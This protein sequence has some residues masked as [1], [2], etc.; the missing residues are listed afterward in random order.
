MKKTPLTNLNNTSLDNSLDNQYNL[1]SHK[2]NDVLDDSLTK[3]L[4]KFLNSGL[5][6]D[7]ISQFFKSELF[8]NKKSNLND[9]EIKFSL[10][11]LR[12]K[13]VEDFGFVLLN[14]S[15]IN[16]IS[17]FLKDKNVCEIG[18]GTGWL[19]HNLKKNG[20]DITP[21]DY[22]P[23]IN[24]EFGFKTLHTQ[25]LNIEGV[26]YLK[27]NNPEVII[28]SWPDYDTNFASNIL[29]N[30]KEGQILIYIGERAGGCTGDDKFF[31]LL[32]KKTELNTIT[33]FI[34]QDNLSWNGVHDNWYVYN[35]IK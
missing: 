21:I 24:S 3:N 26:K 14:E 11:S 9:F 13:F 30:M 12:Y 33:E 29:K 23:G 28:L 22:K 32:S 20:V 16:K 25:I 2:L 10:M 5:V 6:P 7:E 4:Q 17:N 8:F 35:I 19:S 1:L 31:N 15:L 27:E 18:A 34:Q